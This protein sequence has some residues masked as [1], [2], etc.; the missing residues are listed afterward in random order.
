MNLKI[1]AIYDKKAQA[2]ANPFY[3]HHKAE[4]LRGLEDVCKDPQSRLNRHPADFAMYQIGEWDDR[5]G[6]IT[7]LPVPE[8][9]EEALAFAPIIPNI[10]PNITPVGVTTNGN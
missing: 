3:F 1:F 9:L 7:S 6:K 10:S 2:Y 8:F 5:S 4:A